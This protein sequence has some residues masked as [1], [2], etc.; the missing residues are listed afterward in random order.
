MSDLEKN[1]FNL[2]GY[3]TSHHK[4]SYFMYLKKKKKRSFYK[5]VNLKSNH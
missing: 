3:L 5:V 2:L 1:L 4:I